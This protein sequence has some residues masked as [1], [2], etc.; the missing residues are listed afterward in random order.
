[1][2]PPTSTPPFCL[3]HGLQGRASQASCYGT[4][5]Y[6]HV[7]GSSSLVQS[8]TPMSQKRLSLQA[9]LPPPSARSSSQIF[10]EP[11]H[12][13]SKCFKGCSTEG[14]CPPLPRYLPQGTVFG[15]P[16]G[17]QFM[18]RGRLGP[19]APQG[20]TAVSFK[21]APLNQVRFLHSC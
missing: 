1:M 9:H 3:Q 21:A 18:Q 10:H 8:Q 15:S 16:Q 12:G 20:Q 13:P 4:S 5:Q 6:H 17:I 14:G 19:R 11:C 2:S 7:T